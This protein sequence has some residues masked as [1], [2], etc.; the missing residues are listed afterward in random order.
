MS[1]P[2][3][4]EA[5]VLVVVAAGASVVA[6]VQHFDPLPVYTAIVGWGAARAG[7]LG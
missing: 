7:G 2:S 4:S 5:L 3:W 6:V 1:A